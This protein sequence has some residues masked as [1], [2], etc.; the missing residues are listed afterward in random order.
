MK[1]LLNPRSP[2]SFT[3]LSRKAFDRGVHRAKEAYQSGLE[4]PKMDFLDTL[5][6]ILRPRSYSHGMA[7]GILYE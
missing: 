4:Q 1:S 2:D 3:G 5:Y 7:H 6:F